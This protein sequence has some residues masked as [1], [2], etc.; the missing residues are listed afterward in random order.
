[1]GFGRHQTGLRVFTHLLLFILVKLSLGDPDFID[2]VLGLLATFV[3]FAAL[4]L[5]SLVEKEGLRTLV[6]VSDGKEKVESVLQVH[7]PVLRRNL[8]DAVNAPPIA[9]VRHVK[10]VWGTS[11]RN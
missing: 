1:M 11:E 10:L 5:H 9:M 8:V 6:L 3:Y 2:P 4:F 7:R